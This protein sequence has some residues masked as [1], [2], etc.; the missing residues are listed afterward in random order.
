MQ[1]HFLGGP[2]S[3]GRLNCVHA[4]AG[5]RSRSCCSRRRAAHCVNSAST[6][7]RRLPTQSPGNTFPGNRPVWCQHQQRGGSGISWPR[8]AKDAQKPRHAERRP[9]E[10]NVSARR[11]VRKTQAADEQRVLRTILV[12]IGA[13]CRVPQQLL[14]KLPTQETMQ[15]A[16]G[17]AE[18]ENCEAQKGGLLISRTAAAG[19]R[20]ALWISCAR[21]AATCQLDRPAEDE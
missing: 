14:K 15:E 11:A 1:R 6:P 10:R 20:R 7:R 5:N 4:S 13:F 9:G 19:G 3:S 21:A 8:T 17:V 16:C 12:A 2:L 18:S